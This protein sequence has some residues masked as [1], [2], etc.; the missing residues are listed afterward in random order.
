M[1]VHWKLRE[2]KAGDRNKKSRQQP[3]KIKL[4]KLERGHLCPPDF[5]AVKNTRAGDARAPI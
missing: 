4:K 3:G 5:W 1:K 2:I